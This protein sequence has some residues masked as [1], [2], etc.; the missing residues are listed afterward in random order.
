MARYHPID[1]IDNNQAPVLT[2][3]LAYEAHGK[4]GQTRIL[5]TTA[6]SE[7]GSNLFNAAAED[8]GNAWKMVILNIGKTRVDTSCPC[9]KYGMISI[10]RAGNMSAAD[11]LRIES[12]KFNEH[13]VG[14]EIMADIEK[15]ELDASF[16]DMTVIL[17]IDCA[18]S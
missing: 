14:V 13:S 17:Y 6:G 5:T 10:F 4:C 16:P 2:A 11:E 18:Q 9:V 12:T 7:E 1:P 3:D 8:T 15:V